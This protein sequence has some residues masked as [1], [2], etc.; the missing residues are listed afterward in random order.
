MIEWDAILVQ[1]ALIGATLAAFLAV[2]RFRMTKWVSL[3][4]TRMMKKLQNDAAGEEG[5]ETPPGAASPGTLNLAGFKID[6]NT[7]G[8]LAALADKFGFLDKFKGGGGSGGG[9]W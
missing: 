9:G 1:T 8:Q 4:F 5:A 7:I 2:I 3:G 6:I